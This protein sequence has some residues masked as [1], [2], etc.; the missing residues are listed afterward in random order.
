M[1]LNDSKSMIKW[2]KDNKLVYCKDLILSKSY[3]I[4]DK[5]YEYPPVLTYLNNCKTAQKDNPVLYLHYILN[6]VYKDGMSYTD[7]MNIL[8]FGL[9]DSNVIYSLLS[10]EEIFKNSSKDVIQSLFRCIN[11]EDLSKYTWYNLDKLE[12]IITSFT[13][14]FEFACNINE[15]YKELVINQIIDE[16]DNHSLY[17]KDE[18][19]EL[20]CTLFT[21][22]YHI[23]NMLINID[24]LNYNKEDKTKNI[25]HILDI[26]TPI[27]ESK[28][29][30][31]DSSD[32]AQ[33]LT[34]NTT[35][36]NKYSYLFDK[37]NDASGAW[38]YAIYYRNTISEL[39]NIIYLSKYVDTFY[40]REWWNDDIFYKI[41]WWKVLYNKTRNF[42]LKCFN[43]KI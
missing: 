17:N 38:T 3:N 29:S 19:L 32:I 33:L 14:S 23:K 30:L 25:D 28:I 4:L 15:K 22:S 42:A 1:Y 6:S 39:N 20:L 26:I 8:P 31:I 11:S 12:L 37:I 5:I 40:I 41:S 24:Y 10:N 43:K 27:I 36:S 9:F 13:D 21:D 34:T 16:Y 35:L 7:L 2:M 18:V